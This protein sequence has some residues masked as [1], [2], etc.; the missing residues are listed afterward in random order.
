MR[1]MSVYRT[2]VAAV[3]QVLVVSVVFSVMLAL[4][5][6]P[7]FFQQQGP[8]VGPGSWIVCSLVSAGVLRLSYAR[9]G[10][11]IVVSG[12][13]LGAGVAVGGHVLGLVLG[14]ISF[15]VA[16]GARSDPEGVGAAGIE[17]AFSG[18]KGRRPNH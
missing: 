13:V 1:I 6:P 15:G 12:L 5:F 17:P 4:P 7:D 8:L 18:L 14:A 16:V 10:V 3:I 2:L 9:T 11:A